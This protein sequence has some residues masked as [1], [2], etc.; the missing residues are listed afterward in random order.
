MQRFS[1]LLGAAALALATAACSSG[2]P[3]ARAREYVASGDRYAA[4]KNRDEAI[5]QY[6]NAIKE[7]PDWADPHYKLAQT[8]YESG[9]FVNAYSEYARTADLNPA[10]VDAQIKAGTLLLVAGEFAAA[11]TRA[12]L[13]LKADPKSAPAHILLGNAHAGL[14]EPGSALRQIEQ[15][16][17]LEPS[18][19]PAWT[20]LGAVQFL[21]G[22]RQDAAAA[23]E[24]AVALAPQ[25]IDARLALANF[26][27]AS[28]KVDEADKTLRA[29]LSLDENNASAHRTLALLYLSSNRA[30]QAEPHFKA[31]ATAPA[32]RLALAD[33]YMGLGRT[34]DALKLID[35]LEKSKDVAHAHAARLRRASLYYGS[36][37]KPEAHKIIDGILKE[38]PRNAEAR[39]AKARMLLADGKSADA[40]TQAREAVKVDATLPAS[41][42]T[43]GL[44]A[45]ADG[46][47][48]EAEKAFEE[49][50]RLAPRAAGAQL[51]LSRLR[52]ARG[53]SAGALTAARDAAQHRPDSPEAAILVS[54]SLRAQGD[55][56]RAWSEL[57]AKAARYPRSAPLHIE[58]GWVALERK[59]IP[60]ARA[61]FED[62]LRH[63][64]GSLDAQSGL[65]ATHLAGK[66]MNAA[67]AQVAAWRKAAPANRS[68]DTL[69]ARVELAAGKPEEAERILKAVVA[70]DASHLEAYELLGRLY[71]A[72]GHLDR[73]IEQYQTM[74]E[75]GASPTG[76]RTMVGMLHES[77]RDRANAKQAYEAVLARDPRAGIAANNLAWIYADEG[78]LDDA[79]RLARV[80]QEQLRRRPEGED[81]L[82]WVQLKKG[83]TADAIAAF[84]RAV[85]RAPNN[86]VYHYHLGLAYLKVGDRERGRSELQ[87]ALSLDQDFNGADDARRQ[88][89][90]MSGT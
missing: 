59:Q 64:P 74:A 12:E 8:Y 7:K 32:G 50:V 53:E 65:I 14:N 44:A 54:R 36:N 71:V 48:E 5:I 70:A 83:M 76:P 66:D 62:A 11:R 86:A 51:Q 46:K 87:R 58:L 15:A 22:R 19:A 35:E 69:A 10:N 73:A 26:H 6:K 43:A 89:S 45:L 17:T 2:D 25:S 52:L 9:D 24:K 67:R 77:K 4:G 23:F 1:R 29:A 42:Y 78:R 40:L 27:W 49:V 90:Q 33:Y 84:A 79:L 88:L 82:G 80:A 13:A 21:G 28:G 72:Q 63:A 38:R 56:A 61:A 37:R 31:L 75:R 30:P 41:H 57:S 20:A 39:V 68:L 60:A 55:V 34:D 16:I 85:E 81:T 47:P 18:Y 3:E